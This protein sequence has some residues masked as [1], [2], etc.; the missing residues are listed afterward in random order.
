M[1]QFKSEIKPERQEQ[2]GSDTG[3]QVRGWDNYR[4]STFIEIVRAKLDRVLQCQ[5]L[6]IEKIAEIYRA[7][8]TDEKR[9]LFG[10]EV[11]KLEFDA[12]DNLDDAKNYLDRLY[13]EVK[14]NPKFLIEVK[15]K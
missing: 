15:M 5:D 2:W 6:I 3:K 13:W 11:A 7:G 9:N 8:V 1:D 10:S 12:K 4:S 14:K